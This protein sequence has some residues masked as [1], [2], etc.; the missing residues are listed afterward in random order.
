M[1]FRGYLTVL[2]ILTIFNGCNL[3]DDSESN[4]IV[5]DLIMAGTDIQSNYTMDMYSE[6][7]L[8]VGLNKIFFRIIDPDGDLVSNAN[9]THKPIM[10][11]EDKNHSCPCTDP[12]SNA[13][14]EKLFECEIVFIMASG[15]MG[16]WDDTIA[17]DFD[18][19]KLKFAIHDIQVAETNM[20]KNLVFDDD[21][22]QAIYLVTL[23]LEQTEVGLNDFILT[24]HRKESMMSFP[25]V[26]DLQ[27]SINPQMPDM[28]HGSEG[29]V[30]PV[31]IGNGKYDGKVAFNMTGYWTIDFL[32]SRN[33]LVLGTITY[34]FNF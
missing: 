20:K 26:N 11:M 5:N 4:D 25:A 30:N 3:S 19:E 21:G 10:Y 16:Y 23:N 15:M 7:A 1:R 22:T 34:E 29:N 13:N 24:V 8:K 2:S 18:N 31:N 12:G 33:N 14:S 9:I 27:I 28:G 6:E 32:F 17:V